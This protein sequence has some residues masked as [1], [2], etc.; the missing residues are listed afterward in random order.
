MDAP[1]SATL[2][3]FAIGAETRGDDI[4]LCPE[5]LDRLYQLPN[6]GGRKALKKCGVPPF[7]GLN[8]PIA[9]F[10][11][12]RGELED[13][14]ALVLRIRPAADQ[15]LPDQPLGGPAHLRLVEA[16]VHGQRLRGQRGIGADHDHQLPLR[17]GQA[18]FAL[19][20]FPLRDC[21]LRG[22]S[23]DLAR[24]PMGNPVRRRRQAASEISRIARM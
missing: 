17:V 15:L 11:A 21:H 13:D 12:A 20:V 4:D 22:K 8:N 7:D 5:S 18:E 14:K 1:D 10:S 23:I 6:L 24:P 2:P 9:S 16:G 19:E 3:G